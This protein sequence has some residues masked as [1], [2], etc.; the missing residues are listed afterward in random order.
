MSNNSE[1]LNNNCFSPGVYFWIGY[2]LF[3]LIISIISISIT[4]SILYNADYFIPWILHSLNIVFF[5]IASILIINNY[6]TPALLC[7]LI[8]LGI[9]IYSYLK[10]KPDKYN[11]HL[12]E[13]YNTQLEEQYNTQEE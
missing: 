1:N 7:C 8:I 12:E 11:I 3:I 9:G 6:I 4:G 10:I 5:A 13:Q 2:I